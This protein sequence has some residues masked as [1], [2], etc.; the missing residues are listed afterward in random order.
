MFDEDYGSFIDG[1]HMQ[2]HWCKTRRV[3]GMIVCSC[4]IHTQEDDGVYC[5]EGCYE[6]A[7][8]A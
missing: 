7:H 5:G 2:C 3:D 8:A 6:A 4:P 1:P